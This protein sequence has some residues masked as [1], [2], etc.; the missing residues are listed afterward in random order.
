LLRKIQYIRKYKK[1]KWWLYVWN[2]RIYK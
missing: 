1:Y 2:N